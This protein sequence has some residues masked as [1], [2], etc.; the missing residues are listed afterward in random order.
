[1]ITN[2]LQTA[3]RREFPQHHM[4]GTGIQANQRPASAANM[5]VRHRQQTHV[6][7]G[8]GGPLFFRLAGLLGNFIQHIKCAM[9]YLHTLGMPGGTAGVH[10]H[11]HIIGIHIDIRIMIGLGGAPLW[12]RRITIVG[13]CQYDDFFHRGQLIADAVVQRNEFRPDKQDARLGIIENPRDFRRSQTPV[14]TYRDHIGLAAADQQFVIPVR[15]APHHRHTTLR[16]QT[17][18][19]D[20]IGHLIGVTIKGLVID[21]AIFKY[22]SRGRRTLLTMKTG[23][24]TQGSD[25]GVKR[26]VVFPLVNGR[27]MA[28]RTSR[29]APGERWRHRKLF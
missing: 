1:M 28:N 27:Q 19:Q 3:R 25:L 6:L 24:I 9:G 18:G 10:L 11:R 7:I 23:E 16:R 4:L 22:K 29:T 15:V 13:G 14:D 21:L 8:P 12:I 26:H 17:F 20:T 5:K 2:R